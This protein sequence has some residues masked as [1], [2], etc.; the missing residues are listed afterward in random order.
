MTRLLGKCKTLYRNPRL[1][2]SETIASGFSKGK[3][4][5]QREE[6]SEDIKN[7]DDLQPS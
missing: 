7:H 4:R 3:A 2:G 6:W 5:K 1:S